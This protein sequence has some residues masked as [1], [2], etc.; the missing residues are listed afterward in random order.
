VP[1]DFPHSSIENPHGFPLPIAGATLVSGNKMYSEAV[2]KGDKLKIPQFAHGRLALSINHS[3]YVPRL[4]WFEES[5]TECKFPVAQVMLTSASVS[6]TKN[7][8][9]GF[10]YCLRVDLKAPSQADID[11]LYAHDIGL[12]WGVDKVVLGFA[13]QKD[14]I[15]WTA[16]LSW[17]F[18]AQT[19]VENH[20]AFKSGHAPSSASTPVRAVSFDREAI[21][22]A[23]ALQAQEEMLAE[24]Q[25]LAREQQRLLLLQREAEA[26]ISQSEEEARRLLILQKLEQEDREL[27]L[28]QNA[29]NTQVSS[30]P[31]GKPDEESLRTRAI[32]TAG[33]AST[34]EEAEMALAR[35]EMSQ[36]PPAAAPVSQV[37]GRRNSVTADEW[38]IEKTN[39]VAKIM[40]LKGSEVWKFAREKILKQKWENPAQKSLI[41]PG[42]GFIAW[43]G[44]KPMR[45]TSVT[46]GP[47]DALNLLM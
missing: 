4:M 1:L 9:D 41:V 22:R 3:S 20:V 45:F 43:T 29:A 14:C 28:Q 12:T 47:S 7:S 10:K 6:E 23:S 2:R 18:K 38:T 33:K 13:E 25:A 11:A 19:V 8:R 27:Q 21:Q 26:F 15:K 30:Q 34:V 5:D 32:D 40:C 37:K 46:A 16:A 24:E 31:P 17:A 35:M 42:K 44:R 36:P 39:L